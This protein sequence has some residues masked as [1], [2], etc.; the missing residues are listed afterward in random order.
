MKK[1][2]KGIVALAAV[3]VLIFAGQAW[4]D[5]AGSAGI[6]G[7]ADDPVVTKSYV[8][9]K[10]QQALGGGQAP[11]QQQSEP[12]GS[13]L[14]VEELTPGE[15]LYGFEGTEFIVRTGQVI[16]V[17]GQNGDGLTDLTAGVDLQGGDPVGLNHLLLIPRSDSR[18]LRLAPDYDG[19]AYV[20]VRGKYESRSQ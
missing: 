3:G 4:A 15:T 11:S 19:T 5:Y 14:V 2:I 20:I 16:A 9:E 7:S 1:N 6:P 12:Q 13:S 17:P 8:D 18:G 10:I